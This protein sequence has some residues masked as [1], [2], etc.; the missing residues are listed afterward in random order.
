MKTNY[1]FNLFKRFLIILFAFNFPLLGCGGGTSGTGGGGFNISG[2]LRTTNNAP[3]PGVQVAVV[4]SPNG[5]LMRAS[6][7][8]VPVLNKTSQMAVTDSQGQFNLSLNDRPD[9]ITLAF[10]G[11]TF[12]SM[13]D[14]LAVP[15]T[16]TKLNLNLKIDQETYEIN[17][18]LEQFEDDEG[19]EVERD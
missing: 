9:N 5:Q 4:T 13:V 17:E 1:S 11:D 18:E 3:V 10:Q 19:N 6:Y 15:S 14:V 12:D 8:A 7:N 2:T 16:A